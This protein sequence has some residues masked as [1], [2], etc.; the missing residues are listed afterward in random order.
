MVLSC[1]CSCVR[2]RVRVRRIYDTETHDIP[3]L[4][5][6]L[7]SI[8]LNLNLNDINLNFTMLNVARQCIFA[9]RSLLFEAELKDILDLAII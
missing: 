8:N 9:I 3:Y 7:N 5:T 6:M 1:S 2:G 4:A